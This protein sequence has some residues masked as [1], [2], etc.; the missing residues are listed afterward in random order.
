MG[1]IGWADAPNSI[2]EDQVMPE[3]SIPPQ[4]ATIQD[5][6]TE[7][8]EVAENA[9]DSIKET[10]EEVDA[11]KA[12]AETPGYAM[13]YAEYDMSDDCTSGSTANNELLCAIRNLRLTGNADE[14]RYDI[15][16][17]EL[18]EVKFLFEHA[19][20]CGSVDYFSAVREVFGAKH[21]ILDEKIDIDS[22]ES[23]N[24]DELMIFVEEKY[25]KSFGGEV[26]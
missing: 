19:E 6:Q 12:P 15:S 24:L 18:H 13:S 10:H 9:D 21:R 23:P 14:K 2:E 11:D 16:K 22:I 5:T 7:A 8:C 26:T 1:L 17:F 4:A 25:A 20:R 3:S